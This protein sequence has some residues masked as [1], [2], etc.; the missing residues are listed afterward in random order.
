MSRFAKFG[1]FS[2][3][4]P[5]IVMPVMITLCFNGSFSDALVYSVFMPFSIESPLII[6]YPICWILTVVCFVYCFIESRKNGDKKAKTVN[7][8]LFA[9]FILLFVIH[10]I[11]IADFIANF[12]IVF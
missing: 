3:I 2:F 12:E 5:Y 7:I 11:L 6:L 10:M 8:I 1:R 9:T 4:I